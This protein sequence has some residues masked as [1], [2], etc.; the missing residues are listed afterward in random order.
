MA[1][2]ANNMTTKDTAMETMQ[3]IILQLQGEL[4]ILKAKK[5]GQIM[6]NANLSS[7]KKG[8]WRRSKY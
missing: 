2:Q 6:K 7:Y 8:N 5:S 4:K 3:K 1:A